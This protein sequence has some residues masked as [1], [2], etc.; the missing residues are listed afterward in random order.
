MTLLPFDVLRKWIIPAYE[1]GLI[2]YYRESW[3]NGFNV[4][5]LME[6]AL[7]HIEEFF[8]KHE[9]YDPEAEK[10]GVK[11]HHLAGATFSLLACLHTLEHY[12]ELDDRKMIQENQKNKGQVDDN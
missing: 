1:E 5:D 2:K 4:S 7:R 8:Y 11:K 12:P 9:D 10:L 3:R 6:A